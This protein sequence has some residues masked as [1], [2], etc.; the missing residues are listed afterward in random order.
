MRLDKYLQVS[1]LVKR[2]ALA[3]QLCDGGHVACDG[4]AAR[5]ST[6]VRPNMNVRIDYGW[7]TLHLR[8]LEVPTR[9]VPKDAAP[10]LYVVT[11]DERR[12]P[13]TYA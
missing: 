5:A 9:A 2:R 8:V 6:E 3:K 1:R 7:R 10:A 4:R 13:D 12:Q 11:E